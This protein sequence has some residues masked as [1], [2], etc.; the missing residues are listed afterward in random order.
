MNNLRYET[1]VVVGGKEYPMCYTVAGY[2]ESL[3]I[4]EGKGSIAELPRS[5]QVEV[6]LR[7]A[8]VFING[9]I[10]VRNMQEHTQL[11][12]ITADELMYLLTEEEYIALDAAVADVLLGGNKRAIEIEAEADDP[13]KAETAE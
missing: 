13:K 6:T 7:L 8:R 12:L 9:A 3:R 2:I 10:A 5:E 4:M 1:K 11:P